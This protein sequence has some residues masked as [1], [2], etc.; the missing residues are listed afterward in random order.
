MKGCDYLALKGLTKAL[1]D[2][3]N[4]KKEKSPEEKFLKEFDRITS[5]VHSKD[6][7]RTARQK[8]KR[9]KPSQISKCDRNL[10]YYF[11]DKPANFNAKKPKTWRVFGI[12]TAHHRFTQEDIL[13]RTAEVD[14][15]KIKLVDPLS[16][17]LPEGTEL[18]FRKDFREDDVRK[19]LNQLN[20]DKSVID[21]TI[22]ALYQKEVLGFKDTEWKFYNH[23]YNISGMV[24]G[25]VEV[26][27]EPVMWEFKTIKPDDFKFLREPH[28]KYLEQGAM[29]SLCLGIDKIIYH[30]EDKGN[31]DYK[32][33]FYEFTDEHRKWVLDKMQRIDECVEGITL[34]EKNPSQWE[35]N[36]CE[37]KDICVKGEK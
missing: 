23:N 21:D 12:G 7:E 2:I 33:Y 6:N 11:R 13:A 22:K 1:K 26:F 25:V 9:W 15:S 36:W 19:Q 3:E 32:V 4:Q 27:G 10:Y 5:I 31:Q 8:N 20:L 30:Y 18:R 34:P 16:H 35:C 37:Y 29:Y 28:K 17:P 24:D 14:D